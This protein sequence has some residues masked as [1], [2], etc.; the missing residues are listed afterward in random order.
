MIRVTTNKTVI[1]VRTQHAPD[2]SGL[3]VVVDV[4]RA[5]EVAEPSETDRT[6]VLLSPHHRLVLVECDAVDAKQVA[7]SC[8]GFRRRG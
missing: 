4:W 6:A 8:S 1:A 2:F 3:V 7:I 5:S